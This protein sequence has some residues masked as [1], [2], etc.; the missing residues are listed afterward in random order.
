MNWIDNKKWSDKFLPEIK[1][2]CGLHLI[3]EPPIIED[4]QHNTDLIV[5]NMMPKR[6]A[7]RIRRFSYYGKYHND[8]TIR[9]KLP[10]GTETELT[11]IIK[12]FGDYI[13]YGFSDHQ[14]NKLFAWKLADLSI[15]RLWF[16]KQLATGNFKKFLHKN[17]DGSSQFY[18]F[19]WSDFPL[20][21]IIDESK[22]SQQ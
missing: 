22:D 2:I 7:C 18:S 3:G 16:A 12:G 10:N 8:F 20:N 1:Q 14:E 17:T 11:K 19:K 4:M 6:V 5:L 9:A 13:F 21:F 15:F